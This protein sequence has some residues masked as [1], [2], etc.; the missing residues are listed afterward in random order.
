MESLFVLFGEADAPAGS[1]GWLAV[2]DGV[3]GLV[4]EFLLA[5]CSGFGGFAGGGAAFDGVAFAFLAGG[6]EGFSGGGA[7]G[8]EAVAEPAAE[9]WCGGG[10][11]DAGVGPGLPGGLVVQ[12]VVEVG[13][14]PSAVQEVSD[15]G[16]DVL[17]AHGPQQKDA[18]T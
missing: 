15:D 2:F 5:C 17:G 10:V 9:A 13:D 4:V 1:G 8:V 6:A 16:S 7:P 11:G 12:G 18:V 14:G 3:A